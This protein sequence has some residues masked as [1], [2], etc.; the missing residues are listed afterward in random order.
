MIYLP[1]FLGVAATLAPGLAHD[2]PNATDVTLNDV[3][4]GDVTMGTIASQITS[5]TFVY[6]TVYSDAD[7]RKHQS[8]ASLA[9]VLGNSPGTGEF[10]A[11]MA[12]NAEN[13]SIWWRHHGVKRRQANLTKTMHKPRPW[14]L[15]CTLTVLPSMAWF[16]CCSYLIRMI[17]FFMLWQHIIWHCKILHYTITVFNCITY[18]II[19]NTTVCE[20]PIIYA[21]F[22]QPTQ[23]QFMKITENGDIL[24]FSKTIHWKW[25]SLRW[26]HN[27]R[28]SVSNHQP[29]HCLLNR[30]F[31]RRSKKTSKL[32]VT[33]LCVGNSPEKRW[34]PCTNGQLR[35]KCFHLMTSS[36]IGSPN[37]RCRWLPPW[38]HNRGHSSVRAA[39]I[40]CTAL[41]HEEVQRLVKTG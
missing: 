4:Y 19:Q 7:Q 40:H 22:I 13:V 26:R 28:D 17:N 25:N 9:F 12:S 29:H 35:G 39:K 2:W 21:C 27:G 16:C 31:R 18:T 30:L 36:C 34:I 15:I 41:Y 33:G 3:H 5:L 38:Q 11:Q 20:W 24:P 6:S 23:Y 10:P 32:R 1:E 8:S 14:F 37:C